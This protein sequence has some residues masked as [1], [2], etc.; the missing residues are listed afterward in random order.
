M[1]RSKKNDALGSIGPLGPR[2][3]GGGGGKRIKTIIVIDGDVTRKK[4][5]ETRRKEIW[6]LPRYYYPLT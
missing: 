1:V 6:R 2:F 3:L 4:R 5:D